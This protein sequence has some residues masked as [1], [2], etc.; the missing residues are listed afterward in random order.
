MDAGPEGHVGV[1][2]P[3]DIEL[4]GLGEHIRVTVSRGNKPP[5]TIVFMNRLALQLY[6]L[7]GNALDR[8]NRS[9]ITQTLLSGSHYPPGRVFGKRLPLGW[10]PL[11]GES[12]ITYSI[13]GRLV[14]PQQKLDSVGDNLVPALYAVFLTIG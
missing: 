3:R 5:H 1:G 14:S 13:D 7:G 10:M 9:I 11:K 2:I 12:A 8:A 6:V 4:I